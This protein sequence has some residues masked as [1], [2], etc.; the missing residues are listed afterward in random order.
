M[1]FIQM[2]LDGSDKW[3]DYYAFQGSYTAA[4]MESELKRI[5]EE[6]A[7]HNKKWHLNLKARFRVI[8][9]VKDSAIHA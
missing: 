3:I 7:A 4:F 8:K 2:Q 9:V 5:V 6:F 1:D